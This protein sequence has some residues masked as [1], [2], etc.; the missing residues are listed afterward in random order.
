MKEEGLNQPF[1]VAGGS[2]DTT[3]AESMDYAIYA[4]GPE[5]GDSVLKAAKQGKAWK[6]IR[7]EI[8]SSY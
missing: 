1:V 7:D 5:V 4:D 2:V 8:H 3:F 6:D